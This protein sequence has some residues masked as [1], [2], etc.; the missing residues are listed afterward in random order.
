MPR[1]PTR[2][3]GFHPCPWCGAKGRVGDGP[4]GALFVWREVFPSG[5]V[6]RWVVRCGL[7]GARG[8]EHSRSGAAILAWNTRAA[9][10]HR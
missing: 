8:P 5:T 6:G 2:E 3:S 10:V 1:K 9:E 4:G 7:C